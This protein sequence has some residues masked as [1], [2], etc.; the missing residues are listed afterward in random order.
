MVGAAVAPH[1]VDEAATIGQRCHDNQHD[2]DRLQERLIERGPLAGACD[3]PSLGLQLVSLLG[4]ARLI[5]PQVALQLGC[6][7]PED[8]LFIYYAG[9]LAVGLLLAAVRFLRD[10]HHALVGAAT[11]KSGEQHEHR[12][13]HAAL[14]DVFQ[15]NASNG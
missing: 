6:F 7:L 2:A 15:G 8:S 10:L 1:T 14:S 9:D 13:D 4:Y 3:L 11:G 5:S 12:A